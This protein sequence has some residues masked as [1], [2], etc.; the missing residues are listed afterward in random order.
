[1]SVR[2]SRLVVLAGLALLVAAGAALVVTVGAQIGGSAAPP[3]V[4]SSGSGWTAFPR[5][6]SDSWVVAVAVGVP[7]QV[8]SAVLLGVTVL[9]VV[10][11]A[12]RARAVFA[13]LALLA[14]AA[15]ALRIVAAWRLGGDAGSGWAVASRALLLVGCVAGCLAV[16]L[17]PTVD[18]LPANDRGGT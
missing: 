8:G 6:V 4:E 15:V 14:C 5:E 13:P 1:M 7:S 10:P 17:T 2:T 3:L 11:P 9:L 12:G 16:W 18:T